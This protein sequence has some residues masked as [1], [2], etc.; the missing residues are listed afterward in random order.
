MRQDK[1]YNVEGGLGLTVRRIIAYVVLI[2][3][4]ILCLFW[5]YIGCLGVE[6]ENWFDNG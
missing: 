1:E 4:T 5:F 6:N 2:L 3:L